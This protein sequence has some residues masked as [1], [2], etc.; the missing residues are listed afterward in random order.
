M[1]ENG[2]PGALAGATGADVPCYAVAAGT[3]SLSSDMRRSNVL[4]LHLAPFAALLDP[5]TLAAL[6]LVVARLWGAVQ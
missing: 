3:P 5:A 1:A 2:N 6:G 4:T